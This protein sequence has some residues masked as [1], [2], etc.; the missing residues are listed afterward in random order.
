MTYHFQIELKKLKDEFIQ[1]STDV[2]ANLKNAVTCIST[3][4]TTLA[5]EVFKND[6]DIN[7]KEIEVEEECL[8]ILALHQPL[9]I[10]LRYVVAILKVTNDL[11]RIGDLAVN[12]AKSSNALKDSQKEDIVFDFDKMASLTIEMVDKSISSLI[13]SDAQAAEDVFKMEAAVDSLNR[14]MYV[15]VE[16]NLKKTPE[17]AFFLMHN[18]GISKNLERIADHAENIAEDVIFN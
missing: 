9:A 5:E 18:I 7:A 2:S 4:D 11:E 16:S 17:K 3:H 13:N 8:K 1:L 10:D 6:A 15:E 14:E 12:I